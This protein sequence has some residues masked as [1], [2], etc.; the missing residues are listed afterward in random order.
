MK[1]QVLHKALLS[2]AFS[3]FYK[4]VSP[5]SLLFPPLL[6]SLAPVTTPSPFS[7]RLGIRTSRGCLVKKVLCAHTCVK[8]LCS[9]PVHV[10]EGGPAMKVMFLAPNHFTCPVPNPTP[11]SLTKLAPHCCHK[12]S[13]VAVAMAVLKTGKRGVTSCS[14]LATGMSECSD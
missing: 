2:R 6:S 9:S 12:C 5:S 8:P 11:P 1:C 3:L 4:V 13:D 10:W 7:G 14:R